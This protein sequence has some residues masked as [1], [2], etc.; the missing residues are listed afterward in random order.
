MNRCPVCHELATEAL[1]DNQNGILTRG[2]SDL[3]RS[4]LQW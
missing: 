2:F 1:P 4:A 3:V